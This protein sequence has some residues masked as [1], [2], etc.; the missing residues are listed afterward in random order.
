MSPIVRQALLS[1]G[2]NLGDRA[3]VLCD[4]MERLRTMPGILNLEMSGLFETD[5]VGLTDQPRF[6]NLAAGVATALSPETLL[7]MLQSIETEFGRE[8]SVRWGPRTLD[9]DLLAYE[10]EV[11]AS[12]GLTLPHPR[13]FERAFVLVPLR[14]LLARPSFQRPA[15]DALRAQV[16]QPLAD[17]SG[18]WQLG[19]A[20]ER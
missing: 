9:L 4:A 15:W 12:P 10:G 8:R 18:V 19:C 16:A 3:A 2:S 7:E 13:L 1:A 5:P 6:L 11:R 20:P 17:E 14:E